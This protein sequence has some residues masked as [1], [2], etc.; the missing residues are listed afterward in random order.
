MISRVNYILV[1]FLHDVILYSSREF[2]SPAFFLTTNQGHQPSHQMRYYSRLL[3][4]F[5]VICGS[6][7]TK[8]A[9]TYDQVLE[10]REFKVGIMLTWTTEREDNH[11]RFIIESSDNGI[12]FDEI[13]TVT[14]NGTTDII[15][16]Y[17]FL[18]ATPQHSRLYY[19]LKEVSLEGTVSYSDIVIYQTEHTETVRIVRLS[20]A[21]TANDFTIKVDSYGDCDLRWLLNTWQGDPILTDEVVL[22]DGLFDITIP[23]RDL[24]EGIYK[25][26][27]FTDSNEQPVD[28]LTFKRVRG[29]DEP[30]VAPVV[31]KN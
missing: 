27:I 14:G 12:D 15:Q 22:S 25:V 31:R 24:A 21:F 19:R 29:E 20:E 9:C 11:E 4:L 6:L 18:H 30:P 16:R 23:A 8:A 5:F 2:I 10:A 13:G 3:I 1:W 28:V 26:S 17:N 7:T